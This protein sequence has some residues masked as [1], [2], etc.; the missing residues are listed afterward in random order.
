MKRLFTVLIAA[1]ACAT[2]G[3]AQQAWFVNPATGSDGNTGQSTAD[4]F[5][6]L[7]HAL[8]VAGASDNVFC[9]PGTYSGSE[10]FPIALQ[11]GVRVS[12]LGGTPV[13]DGTGVGAGFVLAGDIT[14]ETEIS[15]LTIRDFAIGLSIVAGRDVNGLILTG[16]A[17]DDCA[18]G[19][20]AILSSGATEQEVTVEECSFTGIGGAT[21]V[22]ITVS[23]GTTLSGGWVF[24]NT[25]SGDHLSA[26]RVLVTEDGIVQSGFA[27]ERNTISGADTGIEVNATGGGGNPLAVASAACAIRANSI[28]GDAGPASVGLLLSAAIGVV[29]EGGRISSRIEFNEI[30][31]CGTAVRIATINDLGSIADVITDFYG[32]VFADGTTAILLDATL[33]DPVQRNADPN[34]GGDID[35]GVACL[36]TFTGFVTDFA[37]DLDQLPATFAQYNHFD[38]A[39]VV[40][41]GTVNS[42]PIYSDVLGGSVITTGLV[43]GLAGQEL[44]ITSAATTGF[45]DYDGGGGIGQIQVL[46]DGTA[47]A[48]TDIEVLP[49]GAG[50]IITLPSVSAGAHT[51]TITNPGGQ[52]GE[53][54]FNVSIGTGAGGTPSGCFVATAAHGDYD[55][56]EVRELRGLRDEYLAM[57]GSGRG[58][59]RWYYREGPQAAAW[60]A[61]RP[62]ARATARVALQP[63]VLVSGAL[64]RWSVA[65]RLGFAVLLLGGAFALLRRRPA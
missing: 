12:A 49:I 60:I 42:N 64:I 33:P 38:G 18:T 8:T 1:L 32:N 52:T 20:Q 62:W 29:D 61:E 11:N 63:A 56:P 57:T 37:L 13:F 30:Q 44:S 54:A 17:F 27:V 34:F 14:Q 58:F 40:V 35:G 59:I 21:G 45:V 10:T 47:L 15:G 7:T 22:V 48:Q 23:D 43:S 3:A 4:A 26:V 19:V 24:N 31:D 25:F 41:N 28:T 46:L 6:S 53:F 65:A 51:L 50:A 55:A 39:P 16:V 36:S 5:R 2:S 9:E